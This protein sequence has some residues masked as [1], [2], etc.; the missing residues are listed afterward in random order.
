LAGIEEILTPNLET[1][2]LGECSTLSKSVATVALPTLVNLRRLRLEKGMDNTCP[3]QSLLN[4]IASLPNLT[5]L[6]LIN[7]DVKPGFDKALAKCSNLKTLLIIP[8]Y[9]TQVNINFIIVEINKLMP[10]AI[11]SKYSIPLI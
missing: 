10:I 11:V 9:V 3:T 8:T 7:F 4:T 2:E 1:L 6:E 5:Q